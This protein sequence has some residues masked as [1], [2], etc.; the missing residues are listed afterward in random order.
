MRRL[1]KLGM[2]RQPHLASS[3]TSALAAECEPDAG[4]DDATAGEAGHTEHYERDHLRVS[5]LAQR[6][7]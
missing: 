5:T 2:T 1:E 4:A 3:P 6:E 7:P